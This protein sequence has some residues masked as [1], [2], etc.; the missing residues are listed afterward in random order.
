[1]VPRDMDTSPQAMVQDEASFRNVITFLVAEHI[2]SKLTR[3]NNLSQFES[4]CCKC[5]REISV[6]SGDSA[7]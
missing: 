1:M 2:Q 4:R 3:K 5:V 6:P 7:W